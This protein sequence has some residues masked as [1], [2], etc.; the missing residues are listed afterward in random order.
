MKLTAEKFFDALND[1]GITYSVQA[2]SI[3]LTGN[4]TKLIKAL[5][6]LLDKNADFEARIIQLMNANHELSLRDFMINVEGA[7]VTL[8]IPQ[9]YS[10]TFK[11]GK[12]T[13]RSRLA[14]ILERNVRLKAAVILSIAAK[15]PDLLDVIQECACNR[16][17]DGYTDSL[18]M[19]V[20]CNL[21][22]TGERIRRNEN[23]QIILRPKTDWK[24]EL[25]NF[26]DFR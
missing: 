4:D 19:T 9:L 23:G 25:S 5:N 7:G 24:A 13:A 2:G 26:L 16:W 18:F 6:E 21:T 3:T 20:L 8:E 17:C 14:G 10:L 11:G 12:D 1:R 15:N 22:S